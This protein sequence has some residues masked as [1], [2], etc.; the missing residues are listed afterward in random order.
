MSGDYG[1]RR[2]KR[3]TNEKKGGAFMPTGKDS[4]RSKVLAQA[5]D[6]LE[7]IGAFGLVCAE[8]GCDEQ[9][10]AV[11]AINYGPAAAAGA[12]CLEHLHIACAKMQALGRL[13]ASP[14]EIVE[15]SKE[16]ITNG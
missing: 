1:W 7:A 6:G 5:I 12:S 15:E 8:D 3:W 2:G 13:V 4:K 16:V 10:V 11:F 9:G 14:E